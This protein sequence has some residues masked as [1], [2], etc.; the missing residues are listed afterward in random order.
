MEFKNWEQSRRKHLTLLVYIVC[1]EKKKYKGKSWSN[2]IGPNAKNSV[3]CRLPH[4]KN[5]QQTIVS[6]SSSGLL[7]TIIYLQWAAVSL[8]FSPS[9]A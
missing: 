3:I 6:P 5:S 2:P 4:K 9:S 1:L 7:S 8:P